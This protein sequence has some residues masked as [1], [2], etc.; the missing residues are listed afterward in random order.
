[1]VPEHVPYDERAP[2]LYID[3]SCNGSPLG[4]GG[5]IREMSDYRYPDTKD[6]AKASNR[7]NQENPENPMKKNDHGPEALGRFMGGYFGHPEDIGSSTVIRKAK[8]GVR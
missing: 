3:R 5:L 7:A 1:M 2:K 4:D 6:E 8:V